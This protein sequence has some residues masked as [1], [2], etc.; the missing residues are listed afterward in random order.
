[1]ASSN[2]YCYDDYDDE[3]ITQSENGSGECGSSN[4]SGDK[5]YAIGEGSRCGSGRGSPGLGAEA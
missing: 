4:S 5:R 2:L 1:M 3:S